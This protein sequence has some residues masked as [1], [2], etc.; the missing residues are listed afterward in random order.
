MLV[1]DPSATRAGAPASTMATASPLARPEV[2]SRAGGERAGPAA[3][4]P[5]G[6]AAR[7]LSESS[8]TMARAT[9]APERRVMARREQ[10]MNGVA[11]R[12]ARTTHRERAHGEEGAILEQAAAARG[13]RRGRDEPR[14][15][16]GALLGL[17]AAEQVREHRRHDEE[18]DGERGRGEEAHRRA[19][20]TA[21]RI[22]RTTS[23]AGHRPW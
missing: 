8:S 21:R 7:M 17:A 22:D 10:W 1:V 12:S 2:S 6:S 3:R 16:E 23:V 18:R 14:G 15:R 19:S 11:P 20:A 13:R 4:A 5:P 9:D